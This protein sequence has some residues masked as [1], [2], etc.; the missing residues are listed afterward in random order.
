MCMWVCVKYVNV[1][2]S[3]YV[4]VD[5]WVQVR[6]QGRVCVCSYFANAF[7]IVKN[8]MAWERPADILEGW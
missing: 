8:G 6:A 2:V 4:S 5:I 3:V 7:F 1:H